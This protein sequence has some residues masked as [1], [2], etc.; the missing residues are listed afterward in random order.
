MGARL[1]L[2]RQL[3]QNPRDMKKTAA[4]AALL[5]A[6]S[7]GLGGNRH[8]LAHTILGITGWTY[9]AE[10][11]GF[12]AP[13][14]ERVRDAFLANVREGHERGAQF[15]VYHRGRKVVDLYGGTL[16][17]RYNGDSLQVIFS[18]SKVV[19]AIMVAQAV[20]ERRVADA[21][22]TSK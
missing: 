6:L 1:L 3:L 11:H 17:D 2:L 8:P 9:P 4:W 20:A 7:L 10:V 13:G 16:G 12:V 21:L 5:A 15:V 18:C 14:F 22:V 19:A